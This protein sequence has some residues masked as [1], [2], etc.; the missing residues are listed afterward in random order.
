VLADHHADLLGCVRAGEGARGNKAGQ[1]AGDVA[2]LALVV[3]RRV[4]VG[5]ARLHAVKADEF[6]LGEARRDGRDEVGKRG[7]GG[8][9]VVE[10]ARRDEAGELLLPFGL[11]EAR[12]EDL[13]RGAGDL[14]GEALG[15][16]GEIG[17]GGASLHDAGD[18]YADFRRGRE[19]GKGDGHGGER[20]DGESDGTSTSHRFLQRWVKIGT[21]V[22]FT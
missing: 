2:L 5:D 6:L 16:R 18:E 10:A 13:D 17:V 14:G 1:V 22:K 4:E 8:E 20:R 7:V 19:G 12:L 3:E 11:V 9:D 15:A 21:A